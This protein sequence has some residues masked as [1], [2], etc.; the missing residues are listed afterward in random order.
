MKVKGYFGLYINFGFILLEDSPTYLEFIKELT[1]RLEQEGFEICVALAPNIIDQSGVIYKGHDY[2]GLG[3]VTTAVLL[4]TYDWGKTLGPTTSVAP[5]YLMREVFDYSI[6]KIPPAKTYIGIPTF[7]YLWTFQTIGGIEIAHYV[8][9]N[10]AI[11]LAIEKGAEIQYDD[12]AQAPFYYYGDAPNKINHIVW[13]EDVRS[14]NAKLN[15]VTEYGFRGI[16][17]LNIMDKFPQ[18]WFVINTQYNIRNA[19]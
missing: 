4:M 13:F 19:I 7:G 2:E 14:I 1:A 17:I 11:D 5:V 18:L 12:Y 9:N 16:S 15:L 6:T 10:T 8:S 3:K